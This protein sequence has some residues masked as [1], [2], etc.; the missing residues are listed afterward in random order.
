M[1]TLE[2]I[3]PMQVQRMNRPSPDRCYAC[4]K[5]RYLEFATDSHQICSDC[6]TILKRTKQIRMV[7]EPKPTL[8][9]AKASKPS[10]RRRRKKEPKATY[11]PKGLSLK[12]KGELNRERCLQWIVEQPAAVA[13]R[14]IVAATGLGRRSCSHALKK[15]EQEGKIV[16]DRHNFCLWTDSDR[17]QLLEETG[18]RKRRLP[19]RRKELNIKDV[20]TKAIAP[21]SIGQIKL[22]TGSVFSARSS[23]DYLL[24]KRE[25]EEFTVYG[26]NITVYALK[27]NSAAME[28]LEA[29]KLQCPWNQIINYI[30]S[31]GAGSEVHTTEIRELLKGQVGGRSVSLLLRR[32][33]ASGVLRSRVYRQCGLRVAY[34]L[35]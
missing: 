7:E 10:H 31:L 9:T 30:N 17:S 25:V 4:K 22:A 13:T 23:L 14:E 28:A 12:A 2:Q 26:K 27:S 3:A 21:L 32:M 20:L 35:A 33:A 11:K 18:I 8:P 24:W 6:F 34:S 15:L 29:I 5:Y 19:N 16:R 1:T